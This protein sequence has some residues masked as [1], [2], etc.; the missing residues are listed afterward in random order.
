MIGGLEGTLGGVEYLGNLAVFHLI[1]I[2]HQEDGTLHIG[3]GGNGLLKHRLHLGAIEIGIC[4]KRQ[5]DG[6][7]ILRADGGMVVTAQEV[8]TFVDGDTGEPGENLRLT[9][10]TVETV[11]GLQESILHD[12]V[13]IFMRKDETADLP[14]ELFTVLAHNQAEGST[15][16]LRIL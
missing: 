2:A 9:L 12:I 4:L 11:P 6:G 10:E 13:G 7:F 16:P 5:G 1:V 3:Q 8:E 15:L 14:V